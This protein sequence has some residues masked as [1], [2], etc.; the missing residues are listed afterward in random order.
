M[1]TPEQIFVMLESLFTLY[2]DTL[3]TFPHLY[4]VET[5]GDSYMI[6]SGAPIKWEDHTRTYRYSFLAPCDL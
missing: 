1:S 3:A 5:L 2:D 4:K 6:T